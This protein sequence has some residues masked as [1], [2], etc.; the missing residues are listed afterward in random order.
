MPDK[1]APVKPEEAKPDEVPANA[2]NSQDD[3]E[4]SDNKDK[5]KDKK[6]DAVGA[7]DL[8]KVTDYAEDKEIVS[9]GAELLVAYLHKSY[10]EFKK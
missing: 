3:P 10:K 7:A 8:E 9:T 1:A 6:H 2:Q 5:D 4:N